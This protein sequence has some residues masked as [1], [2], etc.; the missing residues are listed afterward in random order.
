VKSD[1]RRDG[2]GRRALLVNT[3][4]MYGLSR[5]FATFVGEGA[6]QYR[7][8]EDETKALAWLTEK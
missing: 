5:M 2:G 7:L 3:T 1:T 4:L 6:V 8:F